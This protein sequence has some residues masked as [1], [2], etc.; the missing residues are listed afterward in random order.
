MAAAQ[1]NDESTEPETYLDGYDEVIRTLPRKKGWWSDLQ[2]YK[3]FRLRSP[4]VV[5]GLMFIEQHFKS[6]PE[7]I[8]LAS[9]PKCG[10]TW[11]KSLLFA[12]INR[13]VF[14]SSE[15]PL[16]SSNPHH[17]FVLLEFIL[18]ENDELQETIDLDSMPS[19][20]L[21]A[22]HIPYTLLPD[23]MTGSGCKV[24]YICRDPKDVFVSKWH[25]AQKIRPKE[26]PPLPFREAFEMFCNGVS[27]FG[28]FWEHVLSYWKASL[29]A[30]DKVLF[31][32]YEELKREH[33]VQVM[34]LAEFLDKPFAVE[35][36]SVVEEIIK[37]CSLKNLRNLEANEGKKFDPT[38]KYPDFFR[39]GEVGDWR[40][41]LTPEMAEKIDGITI[42]KLHGSGLTFAPSSVTENIIAAV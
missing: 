7:D 13:H 14:S 5:K 24:V 35:E 23:S 22:T 11:L 32:K 37:S 31:L 21:F 38:A 8:I 15:H 26:M 34:R 30:P 20:R 36:H 9:Y 27:H 29:E 2:Q 12:T 19:P 40:N 16:L 1:L 25:F 6:Q 28:P 41:H 39:K 33:V 42:E 10:T 18:D 3:G 4:A 17:L